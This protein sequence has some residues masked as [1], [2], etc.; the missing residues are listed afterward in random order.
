MRRRAFKRSSTGT[1]AN[2]KIRS[3]P[4]RGVSP[5]ET[6]CLRY[7]CLARGFRRSRVANIHGRGI[8]NVQAFEP[9]PNIHFCVTDG[10][11]A[12]ECQRAACRGSKHSSR[13][14]PEHT[15][16]DSR[17]QGNPAIN[18]AGGQHNWSR[19]V[20]IFGTDRSRWSSRA[21]GYWSQSQYRAAKRTRLED[22]FVRC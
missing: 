13:E 5:A 15:R 7:H 6:N 19:R 22:R 8:T 17:P 16:A 11:F 14:H 12:S 20:G 4:L 10:V 3:K 2:L 21:A 1:S 9:S 18:D